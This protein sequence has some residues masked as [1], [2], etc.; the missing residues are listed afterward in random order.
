MEP[1]ELPESCWNTRY[2]YLLSLLHLFHSLSKQ[3]KNIGKDL[4]V[5]TFNNNPAEN[6]DINNAIDL[7][8]PTVYYMFGRVGDTR[9]HRYV[10][11]D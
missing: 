7:N 3:W 2:S 4:K 8:K 6:D 5:L 10:V 11:I 9:S 1:S